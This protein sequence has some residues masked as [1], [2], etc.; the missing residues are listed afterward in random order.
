MEL[1]TK[2][3]FASAAKTLTQSFEMLL[4]NETLFLPAHWMTEAIEPTPDPNE[5]IWLPLN[6]KNL[7]ELGNERCNILF[8]SESELRNF[9]Y[10]VK[11][12]AIEDSSPV[13]DLLL[14]TP[15]G[16]KRLNEHGEIEEPDGT[17]IPNC[18]LPMLNNDPKDIAFVYET[19]CHWVGSEE[20]GVSL[21]H[22]LATALAPGWSA[23]KYVL[24]LGGGRNGKGL[25]LRM[26]MGV[27]GEKNI[28][29]VK[30]QW[31]AE[32]SV[33]IVEVNNKLLNIVMDGPQ[34]YIRD[35]GTEKTIVAG[36]PTSVVLKFEN[37]PTRVQTNALFIEGL[38][39][40]PKTR[41]KSPALQARLARF[42]FPHT[43]DK[44]LAFEA[45]MLSERMLGAFLALLIQHYVHKDELAEKLKP[46]KYAKELQL[47]QMLLNSPMLQYIYYLYKQDKNIQLVG[48][49]YDNF[50]G[51]FMAW[52]MGEGYAEMTTIEAEAGFRYCFTINRKTVRVGPNKT[53]RVR[54]IG[55]FKNDAKQL[56]GLLEGEADDVKDSTDMVEE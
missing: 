33:A 16:L 19:I 40:E 42:N 10:M 1:K 4:H 44:D 56:I 45:Q 20:D 38:N 35:S 27:F 43:F 23:V 32:D 7:R 2:Q 39:S 26:L 48:M 24:L 50:I 41:D 51:S 37:T 34:V 31:M 5:R 9:V 14:R 30:R 54:T 18:L 15:D 8:A 47:D 21:L 55:E 12:F 25:L 49:D 28:S 17:F 46:T 11:Q 53:S 13:V 52:K 6:Q 3:N 22:H 36:E 29:N